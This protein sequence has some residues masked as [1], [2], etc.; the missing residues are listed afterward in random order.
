MQ[1]RFGWLGLGRRSDIL[2]ICKRRNDHGS[3]FVVSRATTRQRWPSSTAPPPWAWCPRCPAVPAVISEPL[4]AEFAAEAPP[5]V[6]TFL[7]T[8]RHDADGTV[9]QHHRCRTSTIQIVDRLTHGSYHDLS[10]A[11]PAFQS[12]Q[13]YT[14]LARS[15]GRKRRDSTSRLTRSCWTQGIRRLPR[16][17]WVAPEGGIIGLRAAGFVNRLRFPFF[18][19]GD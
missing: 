7:L 4:M 6:A 11:L 13:L 17:S 9:A 1:S 12:C 2:R 5:P 10:S 3:R 19:P 15:R 14:S 16:R 18:L 8:A